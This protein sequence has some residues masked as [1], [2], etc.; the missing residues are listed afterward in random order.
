MNK[1]IKVSE[2]EENQSTGL[3]HLDFSLKNIK[4]RYIFPFNENF[5]R[6]NRYK[7]KDN[8]NLLDLDRDDSKLIFE[9]AIFRF[10]F[11]QIKLNLNTLKELQSPIQTKLSDIM[12]FL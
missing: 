12:L 9:A 4:Q 7:M 11:T 2:E 6:K 1:K 5:A 3:A 8:T 10:P